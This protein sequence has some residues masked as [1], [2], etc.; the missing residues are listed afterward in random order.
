MKN[1]KT[2]YSYAIDILGGL[3]ITLQEDEF[4]KR[5]RFSNIVILPKDTKYIVSFGENDTIILCP[6]DKFDKI[7]E[8][9]ND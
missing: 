5:P 6:I 2:K 7:E 4:K 1:T 3:G 8:N 9:N